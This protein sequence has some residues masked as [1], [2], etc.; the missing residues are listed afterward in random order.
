[1]QSH[2][3]LE[4]SCAPTIILSLSHQQLPHCFGKIQSPTNMGFVVLPALVPDISAVYDVYFAAFKDNAV[5][6]ALFPSATAS[7]MTN[8]ES[9]FR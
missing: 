5:T 8:P 1:M 4:D 9:E 7:D 3:E 6:K 2:A